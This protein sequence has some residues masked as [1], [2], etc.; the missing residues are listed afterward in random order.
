M[1][2]A[3][4][5]QTDFFVS[6]TS[7]DE[8][9][10]SWI[11]WQAKEA[12]FTVVLQL[13]DFL[14]GQ[15]FILRMHEATIRARHTL[16]VVSPAFFAS[17]YTAIEWATALA[18]DPTT[19]GARLVPVRVREVDPPGLFASIAYVDLFG[20]DEET[21]RTRLVEALRAVVAG[22]SAQQR[23]PPDP[24]TFPPAA[25]EQRA[26]EAVR[27]EREVLVSEHR[28][29][30]E[31]DARRMVGL[32]LRGRDAV[33]FDRESARAALQAAIT[34]PDAGL[35]L[36][37]GP[38]GIGK[39]ALA[40]WVLARL[41]DE[42]SPVDGIAYLSAR[43]RGL[44][45]ERLYSDLAT[46]LGGDA[47]RQLLSRAT[48][49]AEERVPELLEQLQDGVW[50]VLLDN[51]EDALDADGELTDPA[52]RLFVAQAVTVG[53][54]LTVVVTSREDPAVP[55]GAL[56]RTSRVTFE[57][58][59][60][61][62]M[63]V[64]ML[65]R[66]DSDGG[67]QLRDAPDEEVARA[68][69][70]GHRIPRAL[71]LIA[72]LRRRGVTLDGFYER[73]D[74]VRELASSAIEALDADR[75][76]AVEALAVLGRPVPAGALA[77]MLAAELPGVD[78]QALISDLARSGQIAREPAQGTILLHPV[79]R[80][81]VL[82]RLPVHERSALHRR[83]ADWWRRLRVPR[84]RRLALPDLEPH[85]EEFGQLLLADDP[86]AAA[87]VVSDLENEYRIMGWD[88]RL[89]AGLRTRL[90][91]RLTDPRRRM[92][93][94][95]GLAQVHLVLGPLDWSIGEFR[96]AIDFAEQLGDESFARTGLSWLG[97]AY[98]HAGQ[99][100]TAVAV[101]A[102]ALERHRAARD[103]KAE[104]EWLPEYA[105]ACLYAGDAE[106]A[107]LAART[108]LERADDDA[109]RA[110]ALDSLA[111]AGF[112][113]GR[114]E[115]AITRAEE[116]IELYGSVG[117]VEGAGYTQN[118]L[119]MALFRSGDRDSAHAALERAS[120]IGAETGSGRL[121]GFAA[122][123]LARVLGEPAHARRAQTLLAASGGEPYA[124]A[125]ALA[126]AMEGDDPGAGQQARRAAER[127]PDLL[128]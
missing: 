65:R 122:F 102:G 20:L 119:G 27:T 105:L 124:A 49:P 12:G 110:A 109:A 63:A 24:V 25:S 17:K 82:R 126:R 107:E 70:I 118:V 54:G 59:L 90:Q 47:R 99:Y 117:I 8:S 35:V 34:A 69:A 72:S 39:T 89:V 46:L 121:E 103:V 96:V 42:E 55:P 61:E 95:Y 62:S 10:A 123:N 30:Q 75:L 116:A 84:E 45:F 87:D 58:E 106:G 52:L 114:F 66:L 113:Q 11:A 57:S 79:D 97:T 40:S 44:S 1:P 67:A 48:D 51:L 38:P 50:I 98:R 13:W 73:D 18:Q 112:Q 71:E 92:R 37:I 80:E 125:E 21:A 115:E 91:G 41:E 94:E 22:G 56:L 7:A 76:R 6:Y 104:T 64:E 15:S 16:A 32:R 74:V 108:A 81:V 29:R 100:D 101:L 53:S 128:S 4:D 93:H 9:W 60:P 77:F 26:D 120:E 83:A 88:A 28:R 85:V 111:L 3:M 36:V 23:P 31:G 68:A 5:E 43:T 2:P 127:V 86:D 19:T 14:P 78:A 33:F